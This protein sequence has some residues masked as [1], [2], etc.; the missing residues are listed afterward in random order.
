MILMVNGSDEKSTT[1]C[2]VISDLLHD[3]KLHRNKIIKED[4]D[5]FILHVQHLLLMLSI[6]FEVII[7]PI[8]PLLP[9]FLTY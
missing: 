7:L 3:L 6:D 4:V 1:C 5:S 2:S 9:T 8:Q